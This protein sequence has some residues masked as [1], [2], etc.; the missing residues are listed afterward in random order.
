[1]KLRDA[2]LRAVRTAAQTFVG[3]VVV[4]GVPVFASLDDVRGAGAAFFFA[5][6]GAV[7]AGVVAFVQNFA[8]DNTRFQAPK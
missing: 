2:A 1:M 4:T 5:F 7:F 6:V 8:E 3:L